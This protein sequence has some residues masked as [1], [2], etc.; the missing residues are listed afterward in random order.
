MN[1]STAP[2]AIS[3]SDVPKCVRWFIEALVSIRKTS[4]GILFRIVL[5]ISHAKT[6]SKYGLQGPN[7]EFQAPSSFSGSLARAAEFQQQR[8]HRAKKKNALENRSHIS[9]SRDNIAFIRWLANNKRSSLHM[10]TIIKDVA[11]NISVHLLQRWWA[12]ED[13]DITIN[14]NARILQKK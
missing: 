2:F 1:V 3:K 4:T 8:N 5:S 10:I 11:K 6:D 13:V 14:T 12:R 7:Q 9:K